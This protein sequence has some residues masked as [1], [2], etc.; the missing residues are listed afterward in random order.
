MR[1]SK[2][3]TACLA[4]ALAATASAETIYRWVDKDGVVHFGGLPPAGVQAT[5]VGPTAASAGLT[6][7]AAP[8]APAGPGVAPVDEGEENVSYAEQRRRE[9]AEQRAESRQADAE[10]Q[11]KCAAMQRQ[12]DA[13]EPS[14]RVII[15][16]ENGNPVRMDDNDRLAKVEEAKSYLAAN[17]R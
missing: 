10:R 9:R 5:V 6:G 2:L 16:D 13:L 11:Q 8:A 15:N 4:L 14:T 1:N 7:A 17:C 12:R 3:L